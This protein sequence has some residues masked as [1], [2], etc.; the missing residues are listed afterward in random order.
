MGRFEP[1]VRWGQILDNKPENREQLGVGL[2][3]WLFASAPLKFTYEFNM[4]DVKDDRL[5]FQFAYGF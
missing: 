4:G 5:L 2:N 1:V 3:Y